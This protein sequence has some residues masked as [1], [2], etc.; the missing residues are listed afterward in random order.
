MIL[1]QDEITVGAYGVCLFMPEACHVSQ[2][3]DTS[4]LLNV[5]TF[6]Q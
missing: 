1:K 3:A 4:H 2:R 5:R 6:L